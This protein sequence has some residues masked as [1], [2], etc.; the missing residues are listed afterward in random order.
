MKTIV[1]ELNHPK[2]YLQYKFVA[3]YLKREFGYKVLFVLKKKDVLISLLENDKQDFFLIQTNSKS[4]VS[5]LFSFYSYLRKYN[6]FLRENEVDLIVSKASPYAAILSKIS[7]VKSIITPDSEVVALTNKFVAP[8][9][10]LIITPK[11]F[12]RNFG[13]K[14]IKIA[15]LFEEQYLSPNY[16]QADKKVLLENGFNPDE[17]YVLLRF[18]AWAANHDIGKAGFSLS[19]KNEL[20]EE[21]SKTGKVYISSESELPENLKAYQLKINPSLMHQVLHFANLYVGDSQTMATEAALLGTPSIRCN[22]F[23][24]EKDMN[25]FIFLE[26]EKELLFNFMHAKEAISK[27]KELFLNAENKENW[28]KKRTSYFA[29]HTDINIEISNIIHS[30]LKHA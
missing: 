20:V 18:V 13:E 14:Q 4:L 7:K 25:N 10:N 8:L 19:E 27:A 24:G 6:T 1:F 9:S 23:V 11:V 12:A 26:K 16:F 29:E 5:K 22:S 17:K 3:H 30:F 21:L 28:L 15:G 2:H